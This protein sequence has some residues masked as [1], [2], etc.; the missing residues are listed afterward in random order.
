MTRKTVKNVECGTMAPDDLHAGSFVTIHSSR[1]EP[2]PAWG[3][4]ESMVTFEHV[5][6]PIMPE[7]GAVLRVLAVNLPHVLATVVKPGNTR[8]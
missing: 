3:K 7:M 1:V 5:Y 8:S 4:V 2:R 6:P